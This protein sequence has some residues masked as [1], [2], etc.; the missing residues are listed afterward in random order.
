MATPLSTLGIVHTAISLAPVLIGLYAFLRLGRIPPRGALGE[1]YWYGMLGS[2]VSAF[3]LSS[4]GGFNSG[5]AIGLLALA[6]ILLGRQSLQLQ[7][8]GQ[9][10]PYLE[11]ACMSFSFLLLMIPGLNESL[12]RLP[13]SAPIGN[14]PDSPEVKLALLV[15][16]LLFLV[17]LGYQCQRLRARHA[18]LAQPQ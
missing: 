10:R 14:G 7:R 18:G 1:A 2:V 17:G 12:S 13:P 5:H 15:A 8:L 16:L 4:T 9:L 3:G 11:T 6:V